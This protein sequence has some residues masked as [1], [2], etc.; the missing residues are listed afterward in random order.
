M[1]LKVKGRVPDCR[2]IILC[3]QDPKR[4]ELMADGFRW[5]EMPVH[6]PKLAEIIREE[7]R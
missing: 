6:P 2:V 1:A 7:L 3:G 5:V 4:I